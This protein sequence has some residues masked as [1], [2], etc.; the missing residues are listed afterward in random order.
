MPN[1]HPTCVEVAGA[2]AAPRTPTL[3]M[4][5]TEDFRKAT[6]T[7]GLYVIAD[8]YKKELEDLKNR[9]GQY[10]LGSYNAIRHAF[11][12]YLNLLRLK[13]NTLANRP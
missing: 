13:Q 9:G 11:A 4:R 12:Y 5:I 1:I 8:H 3:Y 2:V 7:G 10:D 6:T